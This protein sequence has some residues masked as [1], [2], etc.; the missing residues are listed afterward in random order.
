MDENTLRDAILPASRQA[1]WIDVSII[2]TL[3]KSSF[4]LKGKR[5]NT[6]CA[7]YKRIVRITRHLMRDFKNLLRFIS[8]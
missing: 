2:E 8:F 7:L 5:S 3:S 4:F 6:G 1:W